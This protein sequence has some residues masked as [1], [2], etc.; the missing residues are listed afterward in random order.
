MREILD[1]DKPIE[2]DTYDEGKWE[3]VA[4]LPEDKYHEYSVINDLST[5]SSSMIDMEVWRTAD[6]RESNINNAYEANSLSANDVF[7][8]GLYVP[9]VLVQN[10]KISFRNF[11]A[12][13]D[14]RDGSYEATKDVF[15]LS[16][17]IFMTNLARYTE[18]ITEGDV[19][20][21]IYD[22]HPCGSS[23]EP[24]AIIL[25]SHFFDTIFFTRVVDALN[26]KVKIY[27]LGDNLKRKI[28]DFSDAITNNRSKKIFLVLH[29]SPSEIIDGNVRYSSIELPKC[30][31]LKSL[32]S[33]ISCKFDANT[34]SIFFQ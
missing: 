21:G 15:D 22:P 10:R 12:D 27:F 31:V 7:R 13:G 18:N 23:S 25:T 8:F 24:C 19:K 34:V 14:F 20:N 26:M 11:I 6:N 33:S 4:G 3:K 30:E 2:L 32:N 5:S 29:W 9:E 17:E 28:K 1:F 16:G